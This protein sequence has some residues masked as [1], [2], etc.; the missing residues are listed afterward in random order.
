MFKPV[1]SINRKLYSVCVSTLLLMLVLG[2]LA[3]IMAKSRQTQVLTLD[4][5]G[6]IT[7]Q[8]SD[9]SLTNYGFSNGKY[10]GTFCFTLTNTSQEI[11]SQ[12]APYIVSI[13]FKNS[14][15]ED[16]EFRII[17]HSSTG[18]FVG[19]ISSQLFF[20]GADQSIFVGSVEGS[21]N[22]TA[23]GFSTETVENGIPIGGK[24][25]ICMTLESEKPF[26]LN[27]LIS[28]FI[29]LFSDSAYSGG[30]FAGN[31]KNNSKFGY[32]TLAASLTTNQ[33]CFQA[34]NNSSRF[35]ITGI[36]F[37]LTPSQGPF[38]LSSVT[39]TPQFN[40]QNFVFSDSPGQVTGVN[41]IKKEQITLDFGVITGRDIAH[42][43]REL[44]VPPLNYYDDSIISASS[45]FCVNGNFSGLTISDFLNSAFIRLDNDWATRITKE[46]ELR[47]LGCE[48]GGPTTKG[49]VGSLASNPL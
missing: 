28:R 8:L 42:G 15:L 39:P 14:L 32:E 43:I 21:N 31:Q 2:S 13:A 20:D 3:P 25:S 12:P 17:N 11:A 34:D 40:K 19:F 41:M 30:F 38:T 47:K 9:Y 27:D 48:L 22:L 24:A 1:I 49:L 4:A 45:T 5:G 6:G 37:D 26:T 16:D 18:S 10:Q 7:A 29:I 44:G 46:S 33:F 35:F 36:G 23:K